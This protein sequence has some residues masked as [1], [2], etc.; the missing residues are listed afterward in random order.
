MA[1]ILAALLAATIEIAAG[2]DGLKE[3]FAVAFD[4]DG[5]WYVCE[6]GGHR[7]TRV[8]RDGRLTVIAGTGTMG[9]SGDG[10]P[11]LQVSFHNP[12]SMMLGRNG[13]LYIADTFNHRVRKLD[14]KTGQITT[15]AGTGQPGY[16]G[17]GGPANRAQFNEAYNVSLDRD[18]THLYVDDLK[19]RRIRMIDLKS[20][21][22]TTVAGNGEK[23]EPK[24]GA[25]A[26]EAPLMDPRAVAVGPGGELY[27][28]ERQGNALRVVAKDGTISTVIAPGQFSPDMR[29]P[30]DLVVDRNGDV[31][32]ADT[33]NHTIRRYDVRNRTLTA[34][35]GTGAA[36]SKFVAS[37][38][39][40]TEMKRPHG[41]AIHPSG[42]LY[43]SDSEN[44]RIL[45]I[46]R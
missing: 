45:R 39:L 34:I 1:L 37:D 15:I 21:I 16:S 43:I 8:D 9:D 2:P 22:V 40:A 18:G 28:L 35:A 10:G 41:V 31:L 27:I 11:A 5:T 44:N 23:G 13:Q 32:I 30:K 14:L 42:D 33:E 25:K 3:P 12:H 17:D 4:R 19:N 20:G 6:Y 38:P 36:G 29:G 26:V 46:R 24:D 7:I